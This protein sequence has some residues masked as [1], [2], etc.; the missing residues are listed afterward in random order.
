LG[1][2]FQDVLAYS[3]IGDANDFSYFYINP[4]SGLISLKRTLTEA[5]GNQFDVNNFVI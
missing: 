3:I 1:D 4:E 5:V 2:L